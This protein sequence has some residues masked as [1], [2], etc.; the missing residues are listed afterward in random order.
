MPSMQCSNTTNSNSS[1]NNNTTGNSIHT[2]TDISTTDKTANI[3]SANTTQAK[4][5][6]GRYVYIYI[7]YKISIYLQSA[8]YI[9]YIVNILFIYSY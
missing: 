7:H 6:I 9:C 2:T 1:S 3:V 5:Y 8:M 4:E